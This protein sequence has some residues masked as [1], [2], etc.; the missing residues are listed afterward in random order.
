MRGRLAWL[1][2]CEGPG[3]CDSTFPHLEALV[4]VVIDTL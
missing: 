2:K 1:G 3:I 4:S